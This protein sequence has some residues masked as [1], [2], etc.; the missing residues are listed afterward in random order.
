MAESLAAVLQ[1]AVAAADAIDAIWSDRIRGLYLDPSITRGSADRIRKRQASSKLAARQRAEIIE[2]EAQAGLKRLEEQIALA[3]S[4]D[5]PPPTSRADLESRLSEMLSR[6]E[7]LVANLAEE[8][9]YALRF[10]EA[11]DRIEL[12]AVSLAISDG[13]EEDD[14]NRGD[15]QASVAPEPAPPNPVPANK[16]GIQ[17]CR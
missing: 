9:P 1:R 8:A 12:L 11:R 14:D 10:R 5:V 2:P 3:L 13:D 15:I 17:I 16:F 7:D 6:G 4:L